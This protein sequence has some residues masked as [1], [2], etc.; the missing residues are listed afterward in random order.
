MVLKLRHFEP[1]AFAQEWAGA[2][3][4]DIRATDTA[5]RD[6]YRAT[7]ALLPDDPSRRFVNLSQLFAGREDSVFVDFVHISEAGNE[8]VATRIIAAIREADGAAWCAT[9]P[10][11]P[12]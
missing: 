8:D 5:L 2:A 11:S 10:A 9:A 3:A 6:L 4:V 7:S 1:S 12:P